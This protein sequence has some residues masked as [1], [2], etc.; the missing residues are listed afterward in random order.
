VQIRYRHEAARARIS[1]APGVTEVVFEV[2]Q[3]AITPGQSAA[4]YNE[5][6]VLG[7]GTI[8]AAGPD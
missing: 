2:P 7:G 4:I 8:C 5:D 1:T 3:R 6:R